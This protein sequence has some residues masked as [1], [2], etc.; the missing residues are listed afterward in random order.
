M[1]AFAPACLGSLLTPK[2]ISNI[3]LF[4]PYACASHQTSIYIYTHMPLTLYLNTL[5]RSKEDL[6]CVA[7]GLQHNL[8][9]GEFPC[10]PLLDMCGHK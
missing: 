2:S 8:D 4:V 5:C 1:S 9:Y 10:F 3:N 7:I 6:E